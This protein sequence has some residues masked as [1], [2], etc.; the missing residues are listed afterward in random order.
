MCIFVKRSCNKLKWD[1]KL[2]FVSFNYLR[3]IVKSFQLV[4]HV[5]GRWN[6]TSCSSF[7]VWCDASFLP[8]KLF[9]T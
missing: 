4:D 3:D 1:D 2:I 6:V 5:P 8:K 9:C 7:N